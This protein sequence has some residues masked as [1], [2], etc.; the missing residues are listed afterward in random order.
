M[1]LSKL[2]FN[3]QNPIEKRFINRRH[4]VVNCIL[5]KGTE[6]YAECL[7]KAIELASSVNPRTAN[8]SDKERER[9][10]K[11]QDA[12]AGVLAEKGWLDYINKKFGQI[13]EPTEFKK[14]NGQIDIQLNNGER[15]EV[16]SSF[17]RNGVKFGVCSDLHSFKIIGAYANLYKP[18]EVQKE[19]YASAL[20]DTKKDRILTDDEIYFS[21]TGG[22]TKEMM[23]ND[24]YEDYLV[25]EGDLTGEKTQYKVLQIKN[26]KDI[27]QFEE[28]MRGIG[29]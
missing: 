12:F 1:K 27:E 4:I 21:L 7:R 25:A 5:K 28:W 26:A 24:G 9:D 23:I 3:C 16:R 22:A 8:A 11:M 10:V 17:I 19:F 15:I 13:A 18:G 29:Y 20:F 2:R 14:A 6:E